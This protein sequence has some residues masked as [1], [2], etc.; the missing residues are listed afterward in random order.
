MGAFD[1]LRFEDGLAIEFPGIGADPFEITWQKK[2][3]TRHNPLM[4]NYKITNAGRLFKEDTDYEHVPEEERPH[5]D[6]DAGGFESPLM[7]AAGSLQKVHHGWSDTDYH[8]IFEFHRTVDG[9]YVSLEA[10]FTDG[11]LVEITRSD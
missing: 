8:G 2:S 3:I 9:D 6:E 1:R 10:K 11:R 7:R 5:Y 4:E